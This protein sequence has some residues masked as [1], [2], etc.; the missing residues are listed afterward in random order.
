MS[1]FQLYGSGIY[2]AG[3]SGV[4]PGAYYVSNLPP[5]RFEEFYNN[6]LRYTPPA[7]SPAYHLDLTDP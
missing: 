1:Q 7:P 4:S 5:F 3:G 2:A 6:Y